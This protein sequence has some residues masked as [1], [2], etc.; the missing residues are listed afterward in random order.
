VRQFPA[1]CALLLFLTSSAFAAGR[2]IG[3]VRPEVPANTGRSAVATDGSKF[4]AAWSVAGAKE[5]SVHVTML[6]RDGNRGTDVT[7]AMAAGAVSA[8]RV[9]FVA[10]TYTV[11]WADGNGIHMSRLSRDGSLLQEKLIDSELPLTFVAAATDGARIAIA[12]QGD[13]TDLRIVVFDPAGEGRQELR[14]PICGKTTDLAFAGNALVVPSVSGELCVRRIPLDG[15]TPITSKLPGVSGAAAVIADGDDALIVWSP[16][17]RTLRAAILTRNGFAGDAIDVVDGSA[18]LDRITMPRL[19]RSG[20]NFLLTFG[21][22]AIPNQ[23]LA[24]ASYAMTIDPAGRTLHG[25]ID[26]MAGNPASIDAATTASR[27]L[28]VRSAGF[29]F[30]VGSVIDLQNDFQIIRRSLIAIVPVRPQDISQGGIAVASN[31]LDF[32]ATFSESH[33]P[34]Y[35]IG[36]AAIGFDGSLLGSLTEIAPDSF[37]FSNGGALAFAP[38]VYLHGAGDGYSVLISRFTANGM[39]ID[40]QPLVIAGETYGLPMVASDGRNFLVVW[41]GSNGQSIRAVV[42]TP[43]GDIG[44]AFTIATAPAKRHLGGPQVAS[45]GKRFVITYGMF[46]ES[47]GP[48]DFDTFLTLHAIAATADGAT[49]QP[50]TIP[51]AKGYGQRIASSG[52]DFLIAGSAP[53]GVIGWPLTVDGLSLQTRFP[54]LIARVD[55]YAF[56]GVAWNGGEYVIAFRYATLSSETFL[57]V[58]RLRNGITSEVVTTTTGPYPFGGMDV[59]VIAVNSLGTELILVNEAR[60]RTSRAGHVVVYLGSEI[61]EHVERPYAPLITSVRHAGDHLTLTWNRTTANELGFYLRAENAGSGYGPIFIPAGATTFDLSSQFAS[62]QTATT[63]TLY[64]WNAAGTSP[65]SNTYTLLPSR[66]VVGRR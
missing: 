50:I 25:P 22:N 4:L 56:P 43:T 60:D 47:T 30:T 54:L 46:R 64:A 39:L 55:Q 38:N 32:L 34:F 49:G 57:G 12:K 40:T 5:V 9:F 59:P 8:L 33:A 62:I 15:A 29:S 10:E 3:V 17:G 61:T 41:S 26:V 18:G 51:G 31:G 45:D 11:I 66:R 7:I 65:P 20:E 23:P 28:L 24:T 44:P 27:A 53:E 37:T 1:F 58:T 48:H 42:V 19:T 63:F 6:D 35:S 16:A 2:E 21:A 13:L 14:F 52:R 36:A